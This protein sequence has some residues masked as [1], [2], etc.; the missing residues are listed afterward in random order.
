[1]LTSKEI[2]EKIGAE[3]GGEVVQLHD[4]VDDLG[5]SIAAFMKAIASNDKCIVVRIHN[6]YIVHFFT[7]SYMYSLTAIGELEIAAD[8][9]LV[10]TP[11]KRGL[12]DLSS[13]VEQTTLIKKNNV[14]A[15]DS[16]SRNFSKISFLILQNEIR[17]HNLH[18]I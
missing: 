16:L 8:Y 11:R 2:R 1:M 10:S 9:T 3:H 14:G 15:M 4:L 12:D 18:K 13:S 17:K 5:L 6:G 7:E